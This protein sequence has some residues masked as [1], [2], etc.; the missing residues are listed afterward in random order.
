[1]LCKKRHGFYPGVKD[2]G[3]VVDKTT[4]AAFSSS[5]PVSHFQ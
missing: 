1:M 5:C 4:L 2:V 3:F